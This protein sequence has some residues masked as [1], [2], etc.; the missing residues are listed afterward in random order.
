LKEIPL[1]GKKAAG[2]VTLASDGSDYALV[3]Q[4]RW[5]VT[6]YRRPNGAVCG[7]YAATMIK[8]ADGRR[9]EVRMHNLILGAA[10]VDH[11]NGDGLDNQR[12]N[13]READQGRN[14]QNAR[15]R[16]G[17]SSRYKGVHKDRRTGKWVAQ[18]TI[19]GRRRHLGVFT[20]ETA[21]ALAY[22]EAAR[23]LF[24]EFARPNFPAGA[25]R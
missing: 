11:R 9:T 13:L 10:G 2:R 12:H 6:E 15:K 5:Y 18:I 16:A 23:E 4:H 20:E 24:G 19:G 22:D 7:P 25:K 21:A 1:Y 17:T 8:G 14:N 3:S